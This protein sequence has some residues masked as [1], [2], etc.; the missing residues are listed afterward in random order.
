LVQ[1]D[2][3]NIASQH[4]HP[5]IGSAR[6][7][8]RDPNAQKP[9]RRRVMNE[10]IT[11]QVIEL[12]SPTSGA[13]IPGNIQSI[14]EETVAKS[15]EAYSRINSVAKDG[16]KALEDLMTSTYAGVRT[17]GEQVLLN[18]EANAQATFDAAQ[19]ISRAKTLPE[20]L[21]I[22][23]SYFQK[24]FTEASA[25]TKE[26]F[27]LWAKVAQQTVEATNSAASKTFDQ[28]KKAA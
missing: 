7:N 22:Q 10:Q 27:D 14:A 9:F 16:V 20:V 21:R 26:L 25:Q 24:H 5:Q 8:G 23:S 12:F 3:L 1:C 2:I 11:R 17:I 13:S 28:L 18:A 4:K 15:R 6:K 19:S